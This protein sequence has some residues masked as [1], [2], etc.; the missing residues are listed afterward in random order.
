MRNRIQYVEL[1]FAAAQ[2]GAVVVTINSEFKGRGLSYLLESSEPRV[3]IV[4]E[5][6]FGAYL[7]VRSELHKPEFE[8][9]II[10]GQ[11]FDGQLSNIPEGMISFERLYEGSADEPPDPGLTRATPYCVIFTSGTTGLPKGVLLP[12][13]AYVNTAWWHANYVLEATQQDVFF[14]CLPFYHCNAQIFTLMTAIMAGGT[15]AM[16]KRFSASQFWEQIRRYRA[17]VFNFLGMMLVALYKQPERAD[18][19][20]NPVTRA[21]GI[22]IP[23]D[24]AASFEQRFGLVLLEA[25]GATETG[26]G[27]VFNTV[28]ERKL[29][30]AG[31]VL[32]YAELRIV[33]DE[34]EPLPPGSLGEII[35]RPKEPWVWM[36]EYYRRPEATVEG[37]RNG[38]LHLGDLGV[39][40]EE[41]WLY[42]RGR[43]GDWIRRRGENI[44]AL[45]IEEALDQHPAVLKSA[46][47]GVPSELTEHEIKA[48]I[49]LKPGYMVDPQ[50]LIEWLKPRVASFMLPKYIEF[51]DELPYT[52]TGKLE[53][54][55]LSR[56]ISKSWVRQ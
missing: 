18:D 22:P 55:K 13:Y 3:I 48:V 16:V 54:Y 9:Y 39:L 56:D 12:N 33:N 46:V 43:R 7:D 36:L 5:E 41:G 49:Q 30:S 25:Y 10:D 35:M 6:T 2:I 38:W 14:S 4:G 20:D 23:V 44:S 32:P 47:I 53:K 28:R 11:Y 52:P 31:K 45:L 29:G 21:F 51:I 15:V 42:F 24:I 26:C 8:Y 19:A 17:T 1:L 37:W 40:D 50:E 27:F 34:D